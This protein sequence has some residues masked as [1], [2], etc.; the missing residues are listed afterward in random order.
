MELFPGPLIRPRHVLWCH[1]YKRRQRGC[2]RKRTRS[3]LLERLQEPEPVASGPGGEHTDRAGHDYR[4]PDAPQR[5]LHHRC[6]PVG[7]YQD[8]Y[9]PRADFS[10]QQFSLA[11][12]VPVDQSR[13]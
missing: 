9:V 6:L 8:A 4:H 2:D 10:R 5:R 7:T 12:L 3:W 13:P 11:V 1:T